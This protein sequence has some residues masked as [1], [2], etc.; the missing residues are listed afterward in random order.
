MPVGPE[1]G[2]RAVAVMHVE[3]DH[4]DPLGPVPGPR[5]LGG[6][7]DIVEKTEAHRTVGLGVVSGRTDAAKRIGDLAG[8]HRIGGAYR[9]AY[10]MENSAQ[11]A[12]RHDLIAIDMDHAAIRSSGPDRLDMGHWMHPGYGLILAFGRLF[13]RQAGEQ[14]VAEHLLKGPHPIRPL[15]MAGAGIMIEKA[16]MRDVQ[17]RHRGT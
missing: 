6:D 17:R 15:R 5:M 16:R 10:P 3:I 13:A 4:G 9:G 14:L 1:R 7:R 8:H 11:R 12:G 2:L